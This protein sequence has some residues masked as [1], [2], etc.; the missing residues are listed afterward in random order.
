MSVG[1]ASPPGSPKS[2][3]S[4]KKS[5][6]ST[7]LSLDLS[8]L[9]GLIHP[10]P[11]SNTLLITNLQDPTIFHPASLLEIRNLINET[12]PIHS[13]APLKSFRRIVTSFHNIAD[14]QRIRDLLDGEFI[15]EQRVRI[16]FGEP[17]P[18]EPV[19]QHLHLPDSGK[20]FFISPPPSPPMGWEMRNEE[21]P[22][23][24]VV[25]ED[26]ASA[27]AKLHGR[28][29][30]GGNATEV[31]EPPSPTSPATD[32][33]SRH[34][35]GGKRSRSSTVVYHPEDHGDSPL[36]PAVM[37]VDTTIEDDENDEDVSGEKKIMAHTARPPV[38]L[39]E[40]A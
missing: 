34:R 2:T 40:G 16:Y 24:Q 25:A 20:L 15:M 4:S 18:I 7:P 5:G 36:L 21:P 6:K 27:L 11:P 26:L 3:T 35:I 23:K 1:N 33:E 17:T 19:D 12:C 9:P 37:V 31:I 30:A 13:W 22:N 29:T 32:D 14:A 10:S 28:P 39:M 38:E 8:N